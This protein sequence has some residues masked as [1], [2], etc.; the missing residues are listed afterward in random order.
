MFF[1]NFVPQWTICKKEKHCVGILF[2]LVICHR[3]DIAQER[4]T[5]HLYLFYPR[6]F[7]LSSTYPNLKW[8]SFLSFFLNLFWITHY[9]LLSQIFTCIFSMQQTCLSGIIKSFIRQA[10]T[11]FRTGMIFPLDLGM[12]IK[13]MMTTFA[14]FYLHK[15]RS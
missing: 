2:L 7:F 1:S 13:E 15:H 10:I 5:K 9:F 12:Q 3:N 14:L 4:N 11:F 6:R 8:F